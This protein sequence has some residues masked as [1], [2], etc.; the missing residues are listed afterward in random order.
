M[1]TQTTF[2]HEDPVAVVTG[3]GRGIGRSV[4][5]ALAKAGWNICLSYKSNAAEAA[6]AVNEIVALGRQAI[7]IKADVGSHGAVRELFKMA[8]SQLGRVDALVN[9]AGVIGDPRSIMEVDDAHLSDIFRTN[10]IGAFFCAGEAARYMSLQ[11]G[12]RGGVIVNM[13]SAAARHG[14][15]PNEAH[16]AASKGAVDSLTLA[17]ARELAQHGIRVNAVRPGLIDTEIHAVHGG[18]ELVA[19]LAATV[20][21]GRPGSS[22]EVADVVAF[23]C[24]GAASYVHGA[25]VDVGGG[26]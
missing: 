17:L 22:Q 8:Q 24:S 16:Y 6:S 21:L 1:T 19:K 7:A 12:G 26:R 14:G 5:L 3:G 23:L 18:S 20:P 10:V 11:K 25:L 4:S 2:P 9:N 15:M 13:S